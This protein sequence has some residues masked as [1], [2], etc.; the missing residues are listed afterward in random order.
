MFDQEH[1]IVVALDGMSIDRVEEVIKELRELEFI[2]GYKISSDM[3]L[4]GGLEIA[5]H[6]VKWLSGNKPVIYDHQKFGT[7]VPDICKAM[8]CSFA[9]AG[10]D[11]F[12]MFPFAGPATLIAVLNEAKNIPELIPI[13]GGLMTH[14]EFLVSEGGNVTNVSNMFATSSMLGCRA[15]VLPGNKIEQAHNQLRNI[16]PSSSLFFPGIGAQSGQ[17]HDLKGFQNRPVYAIVGRAITSAFDPA[18][19]AQ[20]LWEDYMEV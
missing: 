4:Q 9:D 6:Q 3:A 19:A 11:A 12:I 18:D 16:D 13:V 7:D 10:V 20:R 1:G 17:I 14:P 15:F 2:V 8:V 5:V